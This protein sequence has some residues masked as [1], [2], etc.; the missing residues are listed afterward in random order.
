[1]KNPARAVK[2]S[3]AENSQVSGR[4]MAAIIHTLLQVCRLC[5]RISLCERDRK[6][7]IFP[8]QRQ[9]QVFS[10]NQTPKSIQQS[11][12]TQDE[13]TQLPSRLRSDGWGGNP[14][15]SVTLYQ[16]LLPHSYRFQLT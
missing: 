13:E 7:I 15:S 12:V 14:R 10:D 11:A 3:F 6:E 4:L 8:P 9:L 2:A 16:R 5:V 1:M